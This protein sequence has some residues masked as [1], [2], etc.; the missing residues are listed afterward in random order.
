MINEAAFCLEDGVVAE[1]GEARP[2][3]DLR[4]GLP[5]VSRRAA[6]L[7]RRA[8][9]RRASSRALDDLAERLGPRFA[10]R[11]HSFSALANERRGFYPD[12]P[13]STREIAAMTDRPSYGAPADS[14]LVPVVKSLFAGR[15]SRRTRSSRIP[16]IAA[17][18]ARDRL[19]VPRL[20]PRLRAGPHRLARRSTAST[21]SRRSVVRGLAELGAFGMIDPG[22]VRRLRL[23]GVGVLPGDRGDRPD[24]RVARHPDRRPPVD[25]PEG[26]DPLRHRG[27]E[28]E[29]AAAARRRAR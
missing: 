25:R 11:R 18:R 2:R 9:P 21:A 10:P 23:L 17:G 27:A 22:G 4:H 20:L 26:P 1:P 12:A 24:R 5:A 16:E 7:R 15:R 8:R 6:A 19:G 29:V 14:R 28:E 3:D 13:A